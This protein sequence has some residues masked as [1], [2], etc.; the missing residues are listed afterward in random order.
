M[1][2]RESNSSV[3]AGIAVAMIVRSWYCQFIDRF[4]LLPG[5]KAIIDSQVLIKTV[6]VE[7]QA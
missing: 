3:R 7:E 6:L 5:W 1:S 4:V 2:L